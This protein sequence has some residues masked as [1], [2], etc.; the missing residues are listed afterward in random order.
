[1]VI[2][3]CPNHGHGDHLGFMKNKNSPQGFLSRN[4]AI[5]VK[6]FNIRLLVLRYLKTFLEPS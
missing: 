4:Q 6:C 2:V 5:F 3:L 1:M